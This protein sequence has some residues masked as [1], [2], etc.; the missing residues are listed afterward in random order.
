MEE[1]EEVADLLCFRPQGLSQPEPAWWVVCRLLQAS[2]LI[3]AGTRPEGTLTSGTVCE[4][5]CS[6]Q[7]VQKASRKSAP[8]QTASTAVLERQ[9][10]LLGPQETL[11]DLS[12]GTGAVL[13]QHRSTAS[14]TKTWMTGDAPGNGNETETRE[15]LT[16][17]GR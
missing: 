4:A 8:S 7:V 6:P 14:S 2:P 12:P 15:T 11:V 1:E 13:Q 10:E 16:S 9:E 5:V 3:T 17:G